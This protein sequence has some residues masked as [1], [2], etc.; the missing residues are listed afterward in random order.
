LDQASVGSFLKTGSF[1]AARKAGV[2]Q[3]KTSRK[4]DRGS[5]TERI[6]LILAD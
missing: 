2:T 1:S 3:I 5:F 4:M 6:K